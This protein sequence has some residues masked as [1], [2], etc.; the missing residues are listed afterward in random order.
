MQSLLLALPVLNAHVVRKLNG[1]STNRVSS[2]HNSISHASFA[3]PGASR[4]R[5]LPWPALLAGRR[6]YSF[7]PGG[8]SPRTRA[9]DPQALSCGLRVPVHCGYHGQPQKCPPRL[10]ERMTIHVVQRGHGGGCASSGMTPSSGCCRR[11]WPAG[12][13]SGS[14]GTVGSVW[15]TAARAALGAALASSPTVAAAMGFTLV[16]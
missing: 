3:L 5:Q 1:A 16:A 6:W 12:S 4:P 13:G 14:C 2:L 8:G 7:A 11:R 15:A 10:A 9:R